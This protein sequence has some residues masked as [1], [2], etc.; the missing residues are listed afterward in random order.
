MPSSLGYKRACSEGRNKNLEAN[1]ARDTFNIRGVILINLHNI[2]HVR[3]IVLAK[4]NKTALSNCSY[5][6]DH[7]IHA[8]LH[9]ENFIVK[10]TVLCCS[11][12]TIKAM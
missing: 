12:D 1:L 4:N 6:C 11:T 8:R 3:G 5:G 7:D 10:F 9:C 2:H